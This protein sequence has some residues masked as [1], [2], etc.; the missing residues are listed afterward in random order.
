[1]LVQR[2]PEEIWITPEHFARA[3][4]QPLEVMLPCLIQL[5][6]TAFSADVFYC[7]ANKQTN[8]CLHSR[9]AFVLQL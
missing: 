6:L 9:M 3:K 4:K 2:G 1:M 8:L 7:I 5:P